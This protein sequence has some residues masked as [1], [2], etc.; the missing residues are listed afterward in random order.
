MQK[1][2]LTRTESDRPDTDE[3]SRRT[4]AVWVVFVVPF[5]ILAGFLS[6][7]DQLTFAVVGLYWFPAVVLTIIGTVS[8]PWKPFVN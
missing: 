2:L 6:G 4:I 1:E 8:P 5:L 3:Q 7:K